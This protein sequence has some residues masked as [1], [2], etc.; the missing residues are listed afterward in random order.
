[1]IFFVEWIF[2]I[3]TAKMQ[4]QTPLSDVQKRHSVG[5]IATITKELQ[6]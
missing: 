4:Q 3:D 5:L 2:I 1:M 6:K